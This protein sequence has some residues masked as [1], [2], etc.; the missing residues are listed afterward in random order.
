MSKPLHHRAEEQELSVQ[1]GTK[2]E[3]GENV[4]GADTHGWSP[5]SAFILE[6]SLARARMGARG[7][8]STVFSLAPALTRVRPDEELLEGIKGNDLLQEKLDGRQE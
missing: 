4:T 3:P 7:K 1:I 8:C 5:V 2:S 6:S